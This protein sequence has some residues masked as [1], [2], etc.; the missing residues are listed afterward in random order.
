MGKNQRKKL[1]THIVSFLQHLYAGGEGRKKTKKT[2]PL[3]NK[4]DKGEGK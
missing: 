2:V 3:V 4:G 1:I